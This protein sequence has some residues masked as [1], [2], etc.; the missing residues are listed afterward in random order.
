M[1][2]VVMQRVRVCTD[3]G[4]DWLSLVMVKVLWDGR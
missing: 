4:V 2:G 3:E 1:M